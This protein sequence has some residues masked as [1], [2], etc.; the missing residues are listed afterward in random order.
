M[1]V[2]DDARLWRAS[3]RNA[4]CPGWGNATAADAFFDS[5]TGLFNSLNTGFIVMTNMSMTS[6]VVA[7]S[8]SWLCCVVPDCWC[9]VVLCSEFVTK[10]GVENSTTTSGAPTDPFVFAVV[11]QQLPYP[12]PC[13]ETTVV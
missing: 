11:Q 8:P 12:S 10:Y 13:N 5:E 9:C 6:Y 3:L 7:T 2:G 1:C 4:R